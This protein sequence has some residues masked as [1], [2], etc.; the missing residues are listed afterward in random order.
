MRECQELRDQYELY[1]LG[2]LEEAERAEIDRHLRRGCDSCVQGVSEANNLVGA[3]AFAVPAKE[4]SPGLRLR[5][6][7]SIAPAKPQRKWLAVLSWS[8]VAAMVVVS[9][10]LVRENGS[11]EGQLAGVEAEYAALQSRH[12]ELA[13]VADVQKRAVAILSARS[14]FSI[15]LAT[16]AP[17]APKLRAWWSPGVGLMLWGE[18]VPAPAADRTLQLWVVPKTGKPVSAGIFRPDASGEVLHLAD[19]EVAVRDAAELAITDEPAGGR[20]EP[21]TKP[22]WVGAV[23]G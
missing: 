7:E 23:K 3:L 9:V 4:P 19:L 10:L 17:E 21:S 15:E 16:S 12:Q 8:T 1:A 2:V 22:I 13:R 5:L 11:L 14:S 18:N 6:M 20:P